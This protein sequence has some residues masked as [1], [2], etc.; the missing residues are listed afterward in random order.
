MMIGTGD[1]L[2]GGG[3]WI[4]FINVE[5]RESEVVWPFSYCRTTCR[6]GSRR[7]CGG[8]YRR[9]EDRLIDRCFAD[10]EGNS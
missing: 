4:R 10:P 1:V 7:S 6:C 3:Y 2:L 8:G 9:E 5:V